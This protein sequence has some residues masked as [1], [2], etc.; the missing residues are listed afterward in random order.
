MTLD[1]VEEIIERSINAGLATLNGK[2]QPL[3]IEELI[4]EARGQA[5]IETYNGSR[6]LASSKRISGE[7]LQDFN[8]TITPSQQ[9]PDV[10][11]LVVQCPAPVR[12]NSNTDGLV[13]VG[14]RNNAVAFKKATNRQEIAMYIQ[15]GFIKD[16][17]DIVYYLDGN[18]LYIYG[19]KQLK[20]L[21]VSGV[22]QDPT[23]VTGYDI[24]DENY[25]ISRDLIPLMEDY[26]IN[27]LRVAL[28]QTPDIISDASVSNDQARIKANIVKR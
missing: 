25:P 22:F 11:Y 17:K 13:Y 7:W 27:R 3:Y 6:R 28:G 8:L 9:N 4:H 20:N 14:S 1:Q 24:K 19:N 16:G 12:I 26:I 23:A 18:K 2:W 5:I 10:D 15:R 21:A